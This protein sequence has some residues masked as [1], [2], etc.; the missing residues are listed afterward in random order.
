MRIG[1]GLARM[2]ESP[3]VAH[4]LAAATRAERDGFATAWLSHSFGADALTVLTL[5]G[6]ETTSIELGTSVVPT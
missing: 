5:A 4:L 1:I 6:R 2:V 3:T